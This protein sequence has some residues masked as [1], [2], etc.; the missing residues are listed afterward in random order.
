MRRCSFFTKGGWWLVL[1]VGG[2]VGLTGCAQERLTSA[3]IAREG[4]AVA[5]SALLLSDSSLGVSAANAATGTGATAATASTP[6]S[7]PISHLGLLRQLGGAALVAYAL[8][9]PLAP[10]WTITV[11]PESEAVVRLV[12]T[13]RSLTTG[14]NGESWRIFQRA[15]QKVTEQ[16]DAKSYQ[17]LSYEEG[18][19]STRPFA[20]RY[21]VGTLRLV[22]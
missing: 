22:Y 13:M 4:A 21:A 7:A 10:N 11:Q 17:L 15:A 1:V 12:L 19:E 8:Y 6:T 9:D 18:V 3:E 2:A 14:G 16:R 5:G 20:Q